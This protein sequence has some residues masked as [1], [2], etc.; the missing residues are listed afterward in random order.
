M[1]SMVMGE[2]GERSEP[3]E[4]ERANRQSIIAGVVSAP[5]EPPSPGP[6]LDLG[7]LGIAVTYC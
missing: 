6:H 3:G 4:G 2:G 5:R 1:R 7:K